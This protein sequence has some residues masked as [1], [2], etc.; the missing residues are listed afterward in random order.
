MQTNTQRMSIEIV[1]IVPYLNRL[2]VNLLT[3]FKQIISIVS[4]RKNATCITLL[5]CLLRPYAIRNPS[6]V[7]HD[8]S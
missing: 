6:K 8:Y 2:T 1:N 7:T 5:H 3:C 4:R